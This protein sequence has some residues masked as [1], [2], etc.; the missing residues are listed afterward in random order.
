MDLTASVPE[1]QNCNNKKLNIAMVKILI[2]NLTAS[3]IV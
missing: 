1:D 2:N 3:K